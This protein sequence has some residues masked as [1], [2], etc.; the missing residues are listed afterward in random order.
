MSVSEL[1][2]SVAFYRDVLGF[3]EVAREDD[4]AI[5]GGE[6]NSPVVILRL[7]SGRTARYGQ[8]ALGARAINFTVGTRAE[9]DAIGERLETAGALVSRGPLHGSEPLE[10]IMAHDPDRLPL[11]FVAD[12]ADLQLHPDHYRHVA[13]RMYGVDL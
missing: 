9:L 6:G 1:E 3:A 5:L 13:L 2:R 12:E 11:V 4:V 8:Q 7:V 10:V